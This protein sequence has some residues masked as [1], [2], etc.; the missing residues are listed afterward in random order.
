MTGF[1]AGLNFRSTYYSDD[2]ITYNKNTLWHDRDESLIE[3]GA[4]Y[5]TPMEI[6]RYSYPEAK[7]GTRRDDT[8]D[9]RTRSRHRRRK[10]ISLRRKT[11]IVTASKHLSAVYT[12]SN[13][14]NYLG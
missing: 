3:K 10:V 4:P 14:P 11:I 5:A 13:V 8:P 1:S 6:A 2:K 7:S 9:Q 12:V